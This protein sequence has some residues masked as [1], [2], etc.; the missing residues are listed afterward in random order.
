[1]AAQ[2]ADGAN[3]ARLSAPIRLVFGIG[4]AL[5]ALTRRARHL[6][7]AL[8]HRRTLA[9]VADLD[10]HLIADIGL[11]REDLDARLNEPFWR[12]PTGMIERGKRR[13][14]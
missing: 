4:R 9:R 6:V 11:T 5:A 7:V 14:H 10:D 3:L 13:R 2:A 12:D 8:K 1:M